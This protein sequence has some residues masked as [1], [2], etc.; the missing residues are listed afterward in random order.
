MH[1]EKTNSFPHLSPLPSRERE[2]KKKGVDKEGQRP[3]EE[4]FSSSVVFAF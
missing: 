4:G 1:G 2:R 3:T